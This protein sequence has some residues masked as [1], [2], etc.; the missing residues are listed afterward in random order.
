MRTLHSGN[1]GIKTRGRTRGQVGWIRGALAA[2]KHPA[3]L[4]NGIRRLSLRRQVA[5]VAALLGLVFCAAYFPRVGTQSSAFTMSPGAAQAAF[6]A[7]WNLADGFTSSIVLNNSTDAPLVVRPTL[8][9]VSGNA[10]PVAAIQIP[11]RQNV[12][13][14]I[15]DWVAA[16]GAGPTLTQG[17]VVVDY[18]AQTAGSLGA[19]VTV[20]NWNTGVSFDVPDEMPMSFMSS[21]LEGMWW[22]PTEG[23]KYDLV[24]SNM[25]AAPLTATV[26]FDASA[27][28][29]MQLALSPHEQREIDLGTTAGAPNPGFGFNKF[30]GI[31]ISHDGEPGSVQAEGLL[32]DPGKR[33][34]SHFPFADPAMGMSNQLAAAHVLVG[35]PDSPGLP[36]GLNFTAI[37]LFRNV[38]GQ[39]VT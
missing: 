38:S 20:R 24:V 1:H 19:Q 5:S 7:Y 23:S 17:S 34:S 29:G 11:G 27:G 25:S 26:S 6:F 21:K 4:L 2:A 36:K 14:N 28:A 15:A 35:A 37:G 10:I 33:F 16:A 39:A 31:S 22:R 12:R 3:R 18:T 30:G 9:D 32:T 8:Y 13:A